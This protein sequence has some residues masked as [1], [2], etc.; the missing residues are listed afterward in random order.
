MLYML[1]MFNC[2][3]SAQS[4]SPC[5][6]PSDLWMGAKR[7]SHSTAQTPNPPRLA[8]ISDHNPVTKASKSRDDRFLLWR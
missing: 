2:G 4:T 7:M 6:T 3:N 8:P 1:Y 5:S